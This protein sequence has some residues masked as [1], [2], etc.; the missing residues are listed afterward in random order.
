MGAA[1]VPLAA[2]GI[3]G[4][5]GMDA[6]K[7][8]AKS[9]D[10]SR[11]DQKALTQRQVDL[12]D[13]IRSIVEGADLGG[14]FDPERRIQDMERDVMR[15]SNTEQNNLAGA[16]KVLGYKQ[17]DSEIGKRVDSVNTKY[18]QYIGE[19]RGRIRQEAFADRL[20]AYRAINPESLNPGI[21]T[22][23]QQQQ[24]AM[25]QMQNPGGFFGS[26]AQI[27]A[28]PKYASGFKIRGL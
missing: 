6:N 28:D 13:T 20:G 21:S 3:T 19:Q 7:K 24:I 18:R 10:K 25:S 14:Q 22:A 17:G 5:V 8:A 23:G 9:A 15:T 4:L 26:V 2:A 11:K 16:L 12:F 27:M 1:A